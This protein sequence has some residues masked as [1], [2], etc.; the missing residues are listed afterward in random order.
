MN[1]R[2]STNGFPLSPKRR[3]S[4]LGPSGGSEGSTPVQ[5]N[6]IKQG[7]GLDSPAEPIFME[8]PE[9]INVFFSSYYVYNL[10]VY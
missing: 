9:V 6:K 2:S 8:V 5:I 4:I 7:Q 10:L 3:K 1:R